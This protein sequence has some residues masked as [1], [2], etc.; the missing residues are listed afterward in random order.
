MEFG[1][2]EAKRVKT[3]RERNVDFADIVVGFLD[4]L[5]KI[6]PDKRHD[7]G[8]ERFNMLA[9]C[10][11]RVFHITYTLRGSVTWIISAR[12]ANPREQRRYEKI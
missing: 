9:K 1:W 5:R 3:L 8:E 4:P 2:N 10:G 11:R 6:A 7:Y 12:K